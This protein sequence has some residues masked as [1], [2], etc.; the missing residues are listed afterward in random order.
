[1]IKTYRKR[2]HEIEAIQFDGTN[3]EEIC[4]W[5][6]N[7]PNP[8]CIYPSGGGQALLIDTLEGRMRADRYDYVIRGAK[9]EFYPCKPEIFQIIYEERNGDA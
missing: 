9:G 4:D 5:A 3:G 2:P 1:M 8:G 6:L 7:H